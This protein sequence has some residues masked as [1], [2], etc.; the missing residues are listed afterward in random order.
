MLRWNREIE[1]QRAIWQ[2][3]VRATRANG[4]S[5]THFTSLRGIHMENPHQEY[6]PDEDDY[7]GVLAG[8][9]G[10]PENG[11]YSEFSISR[12]A[13]SI[14]LRSSSTTAAS[15][16]N[17][18]M[19]PSVY[20]AKVGR[21]PRFP[22]PDPSSLPPLNTSFQNSPAERGGTSYFSPIEREGQT[23]MTASAR[24]SS[25]SAFGGSNRAGTPSSGWSNGVEPTNRNTAPAMSRGNAGGN[26]YVLNGRDARMRP[27]LPPVTTGPPSAQQLANGI[28]RMRS[29]SS[30]DFNNPQRRVPN[31]HVIPNGSDVPTVPAIPPHVA[32][33]VAPVNRSMNNS[34]T[35]QPPRAA[36][37]SGNT[38]QYGLP[39]AP[40]PQFTSHYTYDSSY[41]SKM[42]PRQTVPNIT[43][44]SSISTIDR[45]RN[46]SPPISTPSSDGEPF[47]PSQLK[48]KVCFDNNYITLVIASNIQFRSLTDRIDAKLARF[49]PAS[50]GGGSVR[51]RYRDED[52]DY[53]WID[54]DEAVHD[55]FLDWRE[56]HAEKIA[57]GSVGEILLFCSSLNGEPL[58]GS[59]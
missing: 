43:P 42:D 6:D 11:P 10:G 16:G 38:H 5:E 39:S 3:A 21:P 51:L 47:M 9:Y 59:G 30:P 4:T 23:P 49:T 55:A 18:G 17:T 46:L 14:S 27:S 37:P 8:G 35:G 31:G 15:A 56:T 19:Y 26:P 58:T 50:I 2:E 12:N 22:M 24:S 45:D 40:R 54:S 13:S 34:P 33:R 57:A 7:N 53:I 25:Q 52:G 48:A 41:T 29:A 32:G 20:P 44:G 1:A 36:T 28:N